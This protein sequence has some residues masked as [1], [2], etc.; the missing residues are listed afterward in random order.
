M[1]RHVF[2]NE[3]APGVK[4]FILLLFFLL[5]MLFFSFA[6]VLYGV[7]ISGNDLSSIQTIV[8]HPQSQADRSFLYAFQLINQIGIFFLIPLLFAYLFSSR[9][10]SYLRLNKTSLLFILLAGIIIFTLLPFINW[11]GQINQQMTFPSGLSRIGEWMKAKENQADTLTQF[12]LNVSSLKGLLLNILIIGLIPALGEELLFRGVLQ[13]LFNEWTRSVP[14]G[15]VI[16]AF[17]F[18]AIHL[19]F[20]GFLPRFV[21][22][23]I[24]GIL[25][26]I[27]QS[28]W[29]PVFAHFVNNTTLVLLYYL[30]NKGLTTIQPENFGSSSHFFF[31]ILSLLLTLVLLLWMADQQKKRNKTFS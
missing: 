24:L 11:I 21:L 14:A 26:E 8:N 27:T 3:T 4:V 20:F 5:G 16:T 1:K 18:S 29:V 9:I 2:F 23:L 19:Q 30:H 22:G 31:I 6:G 17:I 28:L 13:R 12:F 15:I 25:L 10:T 7:L